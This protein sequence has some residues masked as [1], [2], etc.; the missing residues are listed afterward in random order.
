MPAYVRVKTYLGTTYLAFNTNL[1]KF[2]DKRVR[3]ALGMSVDREFITEKLRRGGELPAYA[4]VPPGIANYPGG[5]K[6]YWAAWPLERRQAEA[7]RLLAEVGYGPSNPLKVTIT[8]RGTDGQSPV[9]PSVQADWK[10]VGVQTSIV[11]MEGQVAYA[12]FR[13]R[14]FEIADAAW[15]ADF[16]DATNFLDLNQSS[17]GAQ[18][19]GDYKNP[20]YDALLRQAA[21]EPD[22][23]KR[24]QLLL[25]AEK[26][27]IDDAPI[28]PLFFLV[29]KNLVNPQITGWV[30][31]IVDQHRGRWLCFKDADARRKSGT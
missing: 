6:P 1:A 3:N 17:T 2:K 12:A 21:N 25:K 27:V 28:S 24:A 15:I 19:Y 31:N 14:D 16:N 10:E 9:Y 18:N 13:A 26:I 30:D 20:V 8:Q 29:N 4:F 11:A 5:V 7:R 23:A 22:G